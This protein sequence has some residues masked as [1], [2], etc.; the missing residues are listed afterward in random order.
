CAAV[1][2]LGPSGRLTPCPSLLPPVDP[3]PHPIEVP[4]QPALRVVVQPRSV[5]KVSMTAPR[6]GGS[7][8]GR[9][10]PIDPPEKGRVAHAGCGADV[11]AAVPSGPSP[12]RATQERHDRPR[13]SLRPPPR[14]LRP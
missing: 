4:V 13:S 1:C 10:E 6:G 2:R 11:G 9:S 3:A 12:E 5:V 7:P 8:A 14:G